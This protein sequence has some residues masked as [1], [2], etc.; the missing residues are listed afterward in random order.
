MVQV[1]LGG[2]VF[3]ALLVCVFE[4]LGICFGLFGGE[5]CFLITPGGFEGVDGKHRNT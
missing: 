1:V 4:D 3:D 5:A 2:Q